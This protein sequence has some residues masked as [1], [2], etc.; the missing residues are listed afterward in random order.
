[1]PYEVSL[2][3][4]VGLFNRYNNELYSV[5]KELFVTHILRSARLRWAGH[6]VRMN[7]NEKPKEL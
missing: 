2:F 6:V 3:I 1:L 7:D 4:L 5:Y